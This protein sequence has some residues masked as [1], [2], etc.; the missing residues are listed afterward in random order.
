[1]DADINLGEDENLV[2]DFY[3]EIIRKRHCQ[4]DQLEASLHGIKPT[5]SCFGSNNTVLYLILCN[6]SICYYDYNESGNHGNH[7]C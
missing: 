1:M 7:L 4:E 6:V 2:D 5:R 3:D